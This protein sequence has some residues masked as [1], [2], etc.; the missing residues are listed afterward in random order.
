[1]IKM[2]SRFFDLFNFEKHD[3]SKLIGLTQLREEE[4]IVEPVKT[5]Q[6]LNKNLKIS[7]LMKGNY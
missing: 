2:I 5:V 7:D 1:M 3:N 4:P 6:K